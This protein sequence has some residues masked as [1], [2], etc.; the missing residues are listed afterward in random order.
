MGILHIFVIAAVT[1]SHQGDPPYLH[2]LNITDICICS[3]TWAN[4][5]V[6]RDAHL[7][8]FNIVVT[9]VINFIST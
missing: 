9:K 8:G 2:F 6:S 4:V 5:M 1:L 3:T 7:D